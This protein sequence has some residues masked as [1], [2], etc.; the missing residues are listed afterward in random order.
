MK[1]LFL[2]THLDFGGISIYCISLAEA[3]KEK[4]LDIKIASSAG[5]LSSQLDALGVEYIPLKIRTKSEFSPLLFK[6]YLK[7]E[8]IFKT[9]RPDLIH[10]HTRVTQV[11]ASGIYKR[12]KIPYVST[13]HGFFRPHFGRRVFGF[14]GRKVIA[15][16]EA[17]REHLVN[18]LS[19]K[20]EDICLIHNGIDVEKFQAP[21][22]E[23]EKAAYR[24]RLGIKKGPVIGI[25][26]RLS[27]VKGH[28]YLLMAAVELLKKYPGLELLL[29]G[30]GPQKR[31]LMQLA[32]DLGL[33]ERAFIEESVFNTKLPL[34][35]MDVFVLP[36]IQEGLGLSMMEAMAVGVPVVAS[37]VGGIYSL[38]KDNQ[39][40]ILVNPQDAP[41]LAAGILKL[42][43]HK[44]L[45]RDIAGAA[46]KLI[47]EKFSLKVMAEKVLAVYTEVLEGQ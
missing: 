2:N 22:S 36:S 6:A 26:A 40:G 42:L 39:T 41:S 11:L 4:G 13:C 28:K 35:I 45:A 33:G 24:S 43:Q 19:V 10:A 1:V 34:S 14:W 8:R 16:S 32:I 12:F 3:L 21:V 23:K 27:A 9:D 17:V 30:D 5:A 46:K 20:K 44:Q 47:A 7:L 25:I 37:N 18:D 29:V 15:I 31:A 38:I